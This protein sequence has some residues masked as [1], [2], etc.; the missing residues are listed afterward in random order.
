MT[1]GHIAAAR[2]RFS[3][4]RQVTPVCTLP[5]NGF[6]HPP[7]SASRTASR[8]VEP[9]WRSSRQ[10]VSILYNGPP[11]PR[12][13]IAPLREGSGPPSNTWFLGPTRVH[14]PNGISIGSAVLQGSPSLQTER[15]T[16]R[17]HYSVSNNRPHL[18]STEMRTK[19]HTTSHSE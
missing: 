19:N 7:D 6:L 9:F 15:Q 16:D 10:R 12:L 17:P 1:Q 18:R 5:N 11:L 8:S 14:L 4:I 3:R 13:K 2:R